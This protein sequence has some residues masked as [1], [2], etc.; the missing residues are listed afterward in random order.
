LEDTLGE[1]ASKRQTKHFKVTRYEHSNPEKVDIE[2][3]KADGLYEKYKKETGKHW[4]L[5]VSRS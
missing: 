1:G 2:A 5:R 4:R 3:M